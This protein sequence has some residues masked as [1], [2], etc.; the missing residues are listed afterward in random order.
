MVF[1]IDN[2]YSYDDLEDFLHT[3]HDTCPAN[4][5]KVLVGN[6]KDLEDE[7]KVSN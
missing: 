3:V 7:R 6:K 5:V 1:A 2:K 4:I